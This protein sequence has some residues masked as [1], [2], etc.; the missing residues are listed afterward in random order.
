MLTLAAASTNAVD[1]KSTMRD[2]YF[3]LEGGEWSQPLLQLHLWARCP[4]LELRESTFNI[5]MVILA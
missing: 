1:V 2:V 5:E 4:S 3:R